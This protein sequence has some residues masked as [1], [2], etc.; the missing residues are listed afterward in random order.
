MELLPRDSIQP[1]EI[2]KA[3]PTTRYTVTRQIPTPVLVGRKVLNVGGYQHY[4]Q[5][6]HRVTVNGWSS[7]EAVQAVNRW[8]DDYLSELWPYG[9]SP[10]RPRALKG[11]VVSKYREVPSPTHP[12]PTEIDL[13]RSYRKVGK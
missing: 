13:T 1:N 7:G 12:D 2:V 4:Y 3:E 10:W 6:P 8:V 11:G 9:T 5:Q